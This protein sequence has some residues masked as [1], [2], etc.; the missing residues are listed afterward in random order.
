MSVKLRMRRY[1]LCVARIYKR[2]GKSDQQMALRHNIEGGGET[3]INRG[4]KPAVRSVLPWRANATDQ[5]FCR[6][7]R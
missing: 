2:E 5:S 7:Q 1:I 4:P 3:H 6:V